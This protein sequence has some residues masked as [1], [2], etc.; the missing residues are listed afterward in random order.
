LNDLV[1]KAGD[2]NYN[3]KDYQNLGDLPITET[4]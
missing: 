4:K 2:S 1:I 3:I